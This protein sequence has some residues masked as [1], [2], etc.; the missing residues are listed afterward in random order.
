MDP[1]IG[2]LIIGG[3]IGIIQEVSGSSDKGKDDDDKDYDNGC[4]CSIDQN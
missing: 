1:L 4:N 3:I 2:C